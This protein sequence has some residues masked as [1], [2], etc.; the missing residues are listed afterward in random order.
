MKRT[1][2]IGMAVVLAL[3]AIPRAQA[4][5]AAWNVDGSGNWSL[6]GNWDPATGY[7]NG[8]ADNA[9]LGSKI[10]SDATIT[11][12]ENIAFNTLTFDD[13]NRYTIAGA[14]TLT[15]NGTTGAIVHNN[16]GV[17]VIEANLDFGSVA[18]TLTGTS[19]ATQTWSGVVSGSQYI[20]KNSS[21]TL[22]LSGSGANTHS[23]R[24]YVNVGTV[25][26]N[27]SAGV[28][29]L[30]S[31]GVYVGQSVGPDTLRW[32]ADNQVADAGG[33]QVNS[34]GVLDLNGHTEDIGTLNILNGRVD[35]GAGGML[36]IT[37]IGSLTQGGVITN[38]LLSLRG[39]QR[40]V[41]VLTGHTLTIASV[42]TNG[43]L[44]KQNAGTLVLTAANGH[45]ATYL[46]DA[47]VLAVTHDNALGTDEFRFTST[48]GGVLEAREGARQFPNG[49]RFSTGCTRAV[50]GGTNDMTFAGTLN[51][52]LDTTAVVSN[53]VTTFAGNIGSALDTHVLT[54]AGPG[55]LALTGSAIEY[56]GSLNVT[57]GTLRFDGA[58]SDSRPGV[59][60]IADGGTLSGTGVL[61]RTTVIED[62]GTLAPGSPV[63]ALTVTNKS[64]TL[65]PGS[66]L[67]FEL[68]T[69]SDRVD[70][71][72]GLT[73]D[74]TL[75][76][77]NTGGLESGIYRLFNYTGTL[78]NN[79][80]ALG[81]VPEHFLFAVETDV[82]GQINL[83]VRELGGTLV[84][85]R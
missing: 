13:N 57:E 76:V 53:S 33:I 45:T 49:L 52:D 72:G 50:F 77:S 81:T 31:G 6:N 34:S 41:T 15:P 83:R 5:S 60:T 85:F 43:T 63:G 39:A 73:L 65:N 8:A 9:T 46:S 55:T 56:R 17:A 44:Q 70:V 20:S 1:T 16:T 10:T 2:G 54:K 14:Y 18:R 32:E 19:T 3:A 30:G 12:T 28:Q 74:G 22:A 4:G 64:L 66:V 7:P 48:D 21:G 67:D 62:G 51:V 59:Y 78:T 82:P 84:S 23:S 25:V 69:T 80:L 42:V 24:F 35:I 38:G 40:N 27:K 11:L 61:W 26:L 71:Y 68:G 79:T 36:G 58:F 47:G 75:N 37:G 29:A